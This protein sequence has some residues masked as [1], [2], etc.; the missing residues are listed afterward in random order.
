[1][2]GDVIRAAFGSIS[3]LKALTLI[4][5]PSP[6]RQRNREGYPIKG[7][8][9][10]LPGLG[11]GCDVDPGSAQHRRRCGHAHGGFQKASTAELVSIQ[12]RGFL[13]PGDLSSWVGMRL[14]YRS[15]DPQKPHPAKAL[16]PISA[17]LKNIRANIDADVFKDCRRTLASPAIQGLGPRGTLSNHW[18]AA[19]S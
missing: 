14:A 16:K 18:G 13:G 11:L 2:L 15:I 4:S 17:R 1:M 19:V 6:R 9:F 7:L 10:G 12:S 8:W 5:I 3:L